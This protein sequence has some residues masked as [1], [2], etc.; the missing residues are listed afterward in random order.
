MNSRSTMKGRKLTVTVTANASLIFS[1]EYKQ[2]G[3][4]SNAY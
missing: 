1:T 2:K 4:F 3:V